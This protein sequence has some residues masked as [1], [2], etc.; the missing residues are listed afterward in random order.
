[1]E[2]LYFDDVD[3]DDVLD[4]HAWMDFCSASSLKQLSTRRHIV[5]LRHIIMIPVFIYTPL[6]SV[7]NG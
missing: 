1:M 7:H 3:D 5:P 2:N 4:Q 6:C